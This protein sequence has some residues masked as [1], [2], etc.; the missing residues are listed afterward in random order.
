MYICTPTELYNYRVSYLCTVGLNE[1]W[2]YLLFGK[3]VEVSGDWQ[4]MIFKDSQNS[5]IL[6]K[7]SL[8]KMLSQQTRTWEFQ[9]K[10]IAH[11][12]RERPEKP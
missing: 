1:G 10:D 11:T 4:G 3:M 7:L 12:Q 6:N 5:K 9:E 8:K 2:D